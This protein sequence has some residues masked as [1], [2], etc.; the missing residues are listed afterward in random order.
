MNAIQRYFPGFV[1]VDD[2]ERVVVPFET[3]AQ[4]MEIPWVKDKLGR[5]K[6]VRYSLSPPN[7]LMAEFR[8]PNEAWVIGI[9]EGPVEGLPI[10]DR[11]ALLSRA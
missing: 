11:E 8:S 5:D 6:F 2:S 7:H 1:D 4:L 10:Y 3:L 9:M